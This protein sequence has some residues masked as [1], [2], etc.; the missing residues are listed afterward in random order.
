MLNGGLFMI[1]KVHSFGAINIILHDHKPI[2]VYKHHISRDPQLGLFGTP[3]SSFAYIRNDVKLP[4]IHNDGKLW[5]SCIY[6]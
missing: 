4:F 5:L 3:N 6:M 2:T 1:F